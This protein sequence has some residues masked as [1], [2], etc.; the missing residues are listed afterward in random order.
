MH[1]FLLFAFVIKCHG[2][3]LC[4]ATHRAAQGLG[5]HPIPQTVTRA[6]NRPVAIASP[7][8]DQRLHLR[9]AALPAA[10]CSLVVSC[11]ADHLHQLPRRKLEPRVLALAQY[12]GC[13]ERGP[14]VKRGVLP[15]CVRACVQDKHT[16]GN[17]NLRG[18]SW[19]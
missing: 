10:H 7:P 4:P 1:H 3:A 9:P 17:G 18:R 13:G 11:R 15:A 6:V 5:T 14:A 8:N 2:R 12:D 16:L 19:G